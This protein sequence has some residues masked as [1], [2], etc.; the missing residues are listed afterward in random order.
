MEQDKLDKSFEYKHTKI[1]FLLS[2]IPIHL[3]SSFST[4]SFHLAMQR[5]TLHICRSPE[6]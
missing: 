5:I 6:M 3:F 1:S 2:F 4:V